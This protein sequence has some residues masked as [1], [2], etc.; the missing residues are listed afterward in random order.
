MPESTW[1]AT[2]G[3]RVTPRKE[4]RAAGALGPQLRENNEEVL[5][6]AGDRTPASRT[7]PGVRAPERGGH[8]RPHS[9][10]RCATRSPPGRPREDRQKGDH[11]QEAAGG[12]ANSKQGH[13]TGSRGPTQDGPREPSDGGKDTQAGREGGQPGWGRAAPGGLSRGC[14][15]LSSGHAGASAGSVSVR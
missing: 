12:R 9:R 7:G 15:A 5:S 6:P 2:P 13:G 10:D 3:T 4:P 1:W 14:D 8:P 11:L